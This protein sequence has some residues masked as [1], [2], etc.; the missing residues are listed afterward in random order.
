MKLPREYL[1]FTQHIIDR[2]GVDGEAAGL[3]H[4]DK[5]F[6]SVRG[7]RPIPEMVWES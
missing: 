7:T 2:M 6:S 3:S 4:V 5:P 1:F